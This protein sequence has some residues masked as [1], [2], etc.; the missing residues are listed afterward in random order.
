MLKRAAAMGLITVLVMGG[1][2]LVRAMLTALVGPGVELDTF[3]LALGWGGAVSAAVFQVIALVLAPRLAGR[4]V[5]GTRRLS[6]SLAR[7]LTLLTTIL[8]LAASAVVM[9]LTDLG[10]GLLTLTVLLGWGVANGVL[11]YER[12]L[13]QAR[14]QALAPALLGLLPAIAIL[15][16]IALGLGGSLLGLALVGTVGWSLAAAA[17]SWLL[18]RSWDGQDQQPR[19]AMRPVLTAALPVLGASWNSQVVQRVQDGLAAFAQVGGATIYGNALAL[20]RLPQTVADAVFSATAYPAA[21]Q[22]LAAGDGPGLRA[23]YRLALRAHLAVMVPVA[24]AVLVAGDAATEVVYAYGKCTPE[25][26]ARIAQVLWWSALGMVAISLQCVHSQ[27]LVAAGQSAALLRAELG[28]SVLSIAGSLV[29]LPLLGLGGIIAGHS[30]AQWLIQIPMLLVL[31]RVGLRWQDTVAEL[32]RA[33][34]PV[35]PAVL[36][37]EGVLAWL[38]DEASPWA[39]ALAAGGAVLLVTGPCSM[40]AIRHRPRP[41]GDP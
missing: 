14:G 19:S 34:L 26:V 11:L 21:L 24:V 30:A 5:P 23:A 10:L 13:L 15:G 3:N 18:E 2:F 22:A 6:A 32:L 41:S 35:L 39:R 1:Q 29:A 33:L 36:L 38:G 7:W 16:A 4:P 25:D 9:A 37:A 12:Q 28:L 31:L 8:A 40:W 20:A 27:L 17:A